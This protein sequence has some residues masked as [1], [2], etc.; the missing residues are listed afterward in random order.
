MT[1]RIPF[2]VLSADEDTR[3]AVARALGATGAVRIAA[4]AASPAG[5]AAALRGPARTGLYVDLAGDAEALL[6]FVESLPE[7]RP[8]LL[9]G[10]PPEPALILRAMRAG[11]LAYF[12]EN[13][14]DA[15]LER[16]AARLQ[17][18]HAS[19]A[20]ARR[21]RTVAVLGAKGGVG[22]TTVACE[23]AASLARAGAR[24]A[25]LDAKTSFGDLALRLDATPAYTLADVAARGDDLDAA[26]LASV[27]CRT[28]SGV[29]V[30]AAP[31]D[32]EEAEAIEPRHVEHGLEL[33]LTEFDFVVVDLPRVTDELSLQ[34]LDR[35]DQVLL[36]ATADVVCLARARQHARLLEQLGHAAK[37]RLVLN[38]SAKPGL[39]SDD[40]RFGAL[41]LEPAAFLPEDAAAL[42]ASVDA[43][44]PVSMGKGGKLGAAV[45]ALAS[46]VRDACGAAAS[47]EE[48]PA[49]AAGRLH[50]MIRS[51]RC[52][53]A[54]A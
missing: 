14:L 43:G 50:H 47:T 9:V 34:L 17:G 8:P 19:E 22:T 52:R 1:S 35:A 23:V 12:P 7:P 27:A 10:G 29:H 26:F 20:P 30:V 41:G 32:P 15:E 38:R 53:F 4:D 3:A 24:V 25:A 6:A 5:V 48:A 51:L 11:A 44:R 45:A 31:N 18:E 37:V 46:A 39:L 42:A 54:T 21:G 28:E 49:S 33:L 16:V 40:D 13:E 2:A 36:V